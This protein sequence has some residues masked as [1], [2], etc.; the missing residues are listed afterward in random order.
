MLRNL[1]LKTLRDHRAAILGYGLGMAIYGLLVLLL[2]PTMQ[3][4]EGFAELLDQYPP[5]LKSLFGIEGANFLKIEGFLGTYT[6]NFA[7]LIL[8]VFAV[9]A[10][11]GMVAGEEEGGTLDLLLANP[12]PRW[13]L[14]LEKYGAGVAA[15]LIACL[16][17]AAGQV[18]GVL[19]IGQEISY[20]GLVAASIYVLPLVLFFGTLTLLASAFMRRRAAVGL[21]LGLTIA[22]YLWN[23]L[24][25]M[26][27]SLAPYRK[28]SP[29]Y[30]Y[31]PAEVLAGR[32]AWGDVGILLGLSAVLL[33]ASLWAFR[34][35]DLAV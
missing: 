12:V 35:K 32:I 6:F 16:L 1:F 2:F 11:G 29:F 3:S 22:T 4:M 33:V 30:L 9:N 34:R 26:N 28:I 31:K 21:G 18:V 23:G 19:A 17:M 8:A 24:A 14:V 7:P 15:L 13:R 20:G 27:A 10:A 5:A 25:P